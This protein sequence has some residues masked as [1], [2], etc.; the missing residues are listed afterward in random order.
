[1]HREPN[2][3]KSQAIEKITRNIPKHISEN[4]NQMILK[5]VDL[6]EVEL[7]VRQL[8]AGKAPGPDGFTSNIFH[9][10]WDLIK[11][12]VWQV[13]E[14]SHSLRWM[15]SGVNATFIALVPKVD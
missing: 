2:N 6:Q 5:P 8:K 9:N 1:V 14:E 4:H 15:F 10:F 12:E 3:D 11:M 13:V 7:A